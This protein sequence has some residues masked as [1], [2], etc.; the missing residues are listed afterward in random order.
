MITKNLNC[1]LIIFSLFIVFP[2][3]CLGQVNSAGDFVN[4]SI[5]P[6]NPSPG[7]QVKV[8]IKSLSLDLDRASITW[9][10]DGVEKKT[11]VGLKDYFVTAGTAG[12]NMT[13]G[14]S[15]KNEGVIIK[16]EISFFPAGVDLIFEAVSYTP[17]FYKGKNL[18]P[19]QGTVVVVAFPEIFNQNGKKL[20]TNEI[21]FTWEKDG[22]IQGNY[23]GLGKNYFVFTGTIPVRDVRVSVTATS[24]DKKITADN[25]INITNTSPKIIFY[26]ENPV[27]GI[28]FNKA[29]KNSVRMIADEFKVKAFPYFMSVGYT[30]SP[31]L[32][33]KWSIDG[34]NT[35]GL[36]TDKSAMLFR[37]DKPG[38]GI[39]NIGLKIENSN[40]IFQFTEN[41]F[42]INFEKK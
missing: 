7:Q 26:E 42:N 33:Y 40:R 34:K 39:A 1:L 2:V 32:N 14:A 23:S 30:Q 10:V 12:K 16:K 41:R 6:V 25:S 3:L 29:I 22:V 8:T 13:I 17:P 5:T 4:L 9:Y 15:L 31:D 19:K 20:T 21:V 28:M 24:I 11:E 35:L 27:Y 38:S 36:E 37:Q 18:N